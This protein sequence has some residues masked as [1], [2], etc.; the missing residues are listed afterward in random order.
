MN[1]FFPKPTRPQHF[2]ITKA[3]AQSFHV[4]HD[5]SPHFDNKWHYH[6][7]L[8][9]VHINYGNGMLFIGDHATPFNSGD[10][11]LIGAELPH[12]FKFDTKY[13]MEDATQNVNTSAV[14]FDRSFFGEDF[15]HLPESKMIRTVLDEAGRGIRI[16]GEEKK[17][18]AQIVGKMLSADGLN[19]IVLLI[20]ALGTVASSKNR[21]QLSSIGYMPGT[22]LISDPRIK[23]IFDYSYAN[24]KNQI[25]LDEIASLANVCP[26]SFCRYFKSRTN[27]T[28]SQFLIEIRVGYACRLLI[29]TDRVIKQ[30]CYECGFNNSACFHKYFKLITGKS[31]LTFQREFRSHRMVA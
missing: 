7:E 12:Y 29:E 20:E 30:L 6:S 22:G 21:E 2:K 5:F 14:Y 10:M 3:P 31:P 17:L 18:A 24:F 28:Y 15:L 8:E 27:K 11:F 1:Q 23:A 26:S 19:R 25:R 9:L 4:Q 16:D 13:F